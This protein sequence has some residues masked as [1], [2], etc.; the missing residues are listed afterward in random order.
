MTK[1]GEVKVEYVTATVE[2]GDVRHT[3]SVTGTVTSASE[4]T[5]SFKHSARIS[6]LKVDVGDKIKEGAELVLSEA[7]DFESQVRQAQSAYDAALATLEQ[8]KAGAGSEEVQV[9]QVA[10][11][12]AQTALTAAQKRLTNLQR[13]ST[14]EL[15][16]ARLQVT[17][18]ESSLTA[19]KRSLE[20][21]IASNSQGVTAAETAVSNAEVNVTNAE[22]A[23][24]DVKTSNAQSIASAETTLVNT[25]EYLESAKEYL[26]QIE[27][28]YDDGEATQAQ[29]KSAELTVTQAENSVNAAEEALETAQTA[30]DI[31]ENTA[32][33]SLDAYVNALETARDNLESVRLQ[34]RM[35]ENKARSQ[36]DSMS[37]ALLIAEQSLKSVEAQIAAQLEN[38]TSDVQAAQGALAS[39][40]ANLALTRKAAREVDLKPQEAR[41]EQAGAALDLAL[42]NLQESKII[43]PIDGVVTMLEVESGE[44]VSPGVPVVKV[45]GVSNMQIE[46]NVPETDIDSV[47]LEDMVEITFDAFAADE[48][49][50]GRVVEI[51]P[52]ATVVQGVIYYKVTIELDEKEQRVKS[53]MTANLDIVTDEAKDVLKVPLRAV[54]RAE[55]EYYVETKEAETVTEKNVTIGLEG[56]SYYEIKEGLGEGEEVVTFVRDNG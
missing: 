13:T 26:E 15:A 32:Q 8:M 53:G 50:Q 49:F 23:L 39:A 38:T 3:V 37:V 56:D 25:E 45:L 52:D 22:I 7:T 11:D 16:A 4:V 33:A 40:Q 19:A 14:E 9:A 47:K 10:V 30:A 54:K 17:N 2:K 29:V 46:A 24:D 27:D 51:D 36:V 35:T 6:E 34:A 1:N 5:L 42:E 20:D 12:N 21:T 44:L 31:A 28:D 43:A 18:A 41:V 48:I 55:G